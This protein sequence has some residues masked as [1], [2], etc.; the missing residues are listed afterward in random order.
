MVIAVVVLLPFA[1]A[2]GATAGD[3]FAA[4]LIYGGLLGLASG[5]VA[6]DRLQARQCPRCGRRRR[7]GDERCVHCGYDLVARPRFV[8][9]ERHRLYVEPGLCTC[10][11]RLQRLAV[12]RGLG[13]DVTRTLVFGGMLLVFLVAVALLLRVLG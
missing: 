8:C 6:V 7:R 13:R 2:T 3:V 5:F 9:A 1:V 11:R 4:A 12:P 10:G